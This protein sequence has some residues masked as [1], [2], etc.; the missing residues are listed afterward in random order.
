MAKTQAV[1]TA[2]PLD[3]TVGRAILDDGTGLNLIPQA[4]NW[5][6]GER[7]ICHLNLTTGDDSWDDHPASSAGGDSGNSVAVGTLRCLADTTV[8]TFIDTD[9]W[10]DEDAVPLNMTIGAEC[11]I[12]GVGDQIDLVFS[13]IGGLGTASGT[14]QCT[15]SHNDSERTTTLDISVATNGGEWCRLTVSM[16]VTTGGGNNDYVRTVRVQ[17]PTQTSSLPDPADD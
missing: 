13:L 14:V 10:I 8:R 6:F 7:P 2:N 4:V 12:V 3:Y 5:F 16:Q 1:T 9:V 17:E 15:D 11:H